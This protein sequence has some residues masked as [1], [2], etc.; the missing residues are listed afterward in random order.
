M[1]EAALNFD[2]VGEV[3]EAEF[4][5]ETQ[6]TVL[7]LAKLTVIRPRFDDYKQGVTRIASEAKALTVQD[8]DSLNRA[9]VLGSSAKAI[10][11]KIEVQRKAI[12]ADPQEFID[13]VNKI[14]TMITDALVTKKNS[15]KE[16]TNP[17]CA[18]NVLK[19]KIGQHQAKVELERREAE[20][21]AKEATEALQKKLQAEA[22]EANRKAAAEAKARAEEEQRI[23]REKEEAEAK[24]RGAKK[25]ELEALARKAEEERLEAVRKAEEEAKKNEVMAPTVTAPV[26]QEA[27]RV[28]HTENGSAFSK[29]PWVFEVT[30][31]AA[32]PREFMSVDEKKIRDAVK[33]G[34]RA[35]AGVR[36][37]QDNQI[38][39]RT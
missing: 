25:A 27:P 7:D 38:N 31:S 20:R 22:D 19:N 23:K 16:V 35:I 2:E 28:T 37:Y 39:F 3:V 26:V 36:I 15:K 30:D 18:E 5:P 21:K 6:G 32:V 29:K 9:V 17:D 11:A 34:A 13:G 10:A 33:M 1:G 14:C 4:L 8:Q 12:I 24:E